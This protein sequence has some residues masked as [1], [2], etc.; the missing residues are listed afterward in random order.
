MKL[1]ILSAQK[2]EMTAAKDK[3]GPYG[4]VW[5]FFRIRLKMPITAPKNGARKKVTKAACQP[6]KAPIIASNFTSPPPMDSVSP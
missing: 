4:M 1:I 5:S 2:R 3:N 6:K